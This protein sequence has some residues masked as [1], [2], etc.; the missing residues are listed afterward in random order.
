[1]PSVLVTWAVCWG[2][3]LLLVGNASVS[4]L[5]VG[6]I[7]AAGVTVLLVWSKSLIAFPVR[8]R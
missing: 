7:L 6:A 1:M 2:V 5:V 4:E 3:Y 8:L